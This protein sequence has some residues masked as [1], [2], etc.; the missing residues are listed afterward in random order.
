MRLIKVSHEMEDYV[1]VI[2]T[3]REID[4]LFKRLNGTAKIVYSLPMINAYVVE[5]D[6]HSL[7]YLQRPFSINSRMVLGKE[8]GVT[9]QMKRSADIINLKAAH[10]QGIYGEGVGVA[11][12]DTGC[13]PHPDFVMGKNRIVAFQDFINGKTMPYD[14][15]GHGTHVCGII[16]GNGYESKGDYCGVAPRCNLIPVKVLNQKGNGNVADVLAGLQWVVDHKQQY[17][18]RVVNISVGTTSNDSIDEN[19]LLVKAV[20]A[21][22]DAG[23]V[24]VVAA[25]NNGPKPRSIS[26]P[27]ISRKVITVGAFDDDIPVEINGNGRSRDYSGRGPTNACIKKPD[28][29]AP[30]SNIISCNLV[31]N[32]N[33]RNTR[34]PMGL[35]SPRK[36]PNMYT[37]K[38]GTSMATPIVSGAIALLLSKYPSLTTQQV[39]LKC[40]SSSTDLG[41]PWSKQGWGLLNVKELVK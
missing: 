3:N 22:W 34:G 17:N 40:K 13:Y 8:P 7:K 12:M 30:G 28:I 1:Q 26:T 25:G 4:Y 24:V 9:A 41:Q 14:D 10:T 27:G 19:S 5:I 32:N 36:E 20:D 11:V 23:I 6:R 29:V 15:C 16:A 35:F 33:L 2:I 18:I 38:S 31:R 39:K 21:V 37:T